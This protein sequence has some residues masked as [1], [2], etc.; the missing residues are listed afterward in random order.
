MGL[1]SKPTLVTLKQACAAVG[2][3]ELMYLY[4]EGFNKFSITTAQLLLTED[5]FSNRKKYL[6]LRGTLNALLELGV[7]PIIN[8]NDA[9]STSEIE[10]YDEDGIRYA[11][12]IMTNYLPLL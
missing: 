11:S 7:I 9:I 5:D 3:G 6:N 10:C 1:D 12:A 8:E 2:Q 4:E